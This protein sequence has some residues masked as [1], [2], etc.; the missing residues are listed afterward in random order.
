MGR[1]HMDNLIGELADIREKLIPEMPEMLIGFYSSVSGIKGFLGHLL[2]L[3]GYG[4]IVDKGLE[5]ISLALNIIFSCFQTVCQLS[6]S[7][8][9]ISWASR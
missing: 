7:S 2:V 5:S 6:A 1:Q 4:P 3:Q 9:S 8:V